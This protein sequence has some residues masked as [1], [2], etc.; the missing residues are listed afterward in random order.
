M[1]IQIVMDDTG[2]SRHFFDK[3][4]RRGSLRLNGDL[5]SSLIRGLPPPRGGRAVN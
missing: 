1:A 5:S 2:D 3:L 4:I